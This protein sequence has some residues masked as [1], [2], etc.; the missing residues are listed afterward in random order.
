[1]KRLHRKPYT[2]DGFKK[3]KMPKDLYQ[4]ILSWYFENQKKSI[5]EIE[6]NKNFIGIK[7]IN[8]QSPS[9]QIIH[10]NEDR[11]LTHE[12]NKIMLKEVT[13]WS[14]VNNLIHTSTYGIRMYERGDVLISHTDHPETHILSVICSIHQED[15]DEPWAL[16]IKDSK[17]WWNEVYLA[18][19]E[20]LFYESDI[21]EHGRMRPLKGNRYSNMY[22]HFK[23]KDYKYESNVEP[24][25][26]I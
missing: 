12:F 21:L 11:I 6:Y 4:K 9:T 17:G 2:I 7:N 8:K 18:P 22:G 14:G 3:L 20:M 5:I 19:G 26:I 24:I 16:E 25:S 13:K 10:I 23:P 15:M 1:M